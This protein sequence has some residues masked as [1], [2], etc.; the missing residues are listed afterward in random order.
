MAKKRSYYCRPDGLFETIRT[1]NGKRVAFRGRT[2]A[3]VDRK[4]LAYHEDAEKGRYVPDIV[5][6]WF[7]TLEGKV[8]DNTIA[9]YKPKVKRMKQAFEGVRA[10]EVETLDIMRALRDYETQGYC[11][12]ACATYLS[13]MRMVFDHALLRDVRINPVNGV[14][15]SKGLPSGTRRA[16]TE[17]EERKVFEFRGEDWLL[18]YMLAYTGCRRGELLALEWKDI[19]RKA[20]VIHVT[21]KYDNR[22]H[23]VDQYLKSKNGRRDIP[24]FAPLERVLPKNRIGLLFPGKDGGHMGGSEFGRRWE[25]YCKAAG[26]GDDVVAHCFRHTMATLCYEAGMDSRAAARVLGDTVQV[27]EQVYTEL[28][29]KHHQDQVDRLNAYLQMREES[30]KEQAGGAQ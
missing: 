26:L 12:G 14:K 21:K 4:L 13:V 25:K 8:V 22:L 27:V 10:G 28:R 6:E 18:G 23:R 9:T 19:D 24:I 29:E 16:L 1:I 5:D 2:C 15:L 30:W 7:D 17:E 11:H 3:E 20:G